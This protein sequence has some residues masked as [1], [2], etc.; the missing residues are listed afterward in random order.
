MILHN[1]FNADLGRRIDYYDVTY[2][3]ELAEPVI[4]KFREFMEQ[5]AQGQI[6]PQA[7][8]VFAE[9]IEDEDVRYHVETGLNNSY[10]RSLT[11]P[12]PTP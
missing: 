10:S 4:A 3:K 6:T 11:S 8:A 12:G 9:S 2:R 1:R 5:A 7:I